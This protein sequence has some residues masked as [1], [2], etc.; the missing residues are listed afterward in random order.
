MGQIIPVPVAVCITKFDLLVTRTRFRARSVPF[1]RQI[2]R[3]DE[4]AAE[5]DHDRHDSEAE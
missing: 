5:A 1:I 2:L 3:E 4:S